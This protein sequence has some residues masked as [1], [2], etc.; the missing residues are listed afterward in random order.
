ML[1]IT[2]T[3]DSA[4]NQKWASIAAWISYRRYGVFAG[5]TADEFYSRHKEQEAFANFLNELLEVAYAVME[6]F[7]N[8]LDRYSDSR[9]LWNCCLREWMQLDRQFD[10]HGGDLAELL[11]RNLLRPLQ[12]ITNPFSDSEATAHN[13]LLFEYAI[14]LR[15][16]PAKQRKIKRFKICRWD[17]L[18]DYAREY[19]FAQDDR[20]KTPL[21]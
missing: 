6:Q 20:S 16:M 19:A 1:E 17:R 21:S 9:D 11:R 5:M 14:A 12:K 18:I 3:T 4:H 2:E 10:Q 15:K 13:Y 8:L 7:P